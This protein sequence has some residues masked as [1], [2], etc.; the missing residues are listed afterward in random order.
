[1]FWTMQAR[2][3]LTKALEQ[4]VYDDLID[5]KLDALYDAHDMHRLI[6]CAAAAVR[7]TARSRPRMTQVSLPWR[8]I[9]CHGVTYQLKWLLFFFKK[10]IR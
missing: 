4:H 8:R 1:M 9:K 5:P 6:S 2:P 3:Q 10:I 7:H